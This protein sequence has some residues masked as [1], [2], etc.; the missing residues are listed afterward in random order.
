MI[1]QTKIKSG[2][3]KEILIQNII[4]RK[5]K[6]TIVIEKKLCNRKN[7]LQASQN[8][9]QKGI[10]SYMEGYTRIQRNRCVEMG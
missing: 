8:F 9:T 10:F 2:L 5:V 6:G 3:T 7:D 1:C 4:V